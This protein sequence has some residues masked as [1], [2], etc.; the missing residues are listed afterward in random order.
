MI[1]PITG[2]AWVFGDNIDT[3]ALAPGHH[4]KGS[5]EEMASHCLETIAP[6]FA[7]AVSPGDVLVAGENFGI[8]SS[9]EQAVQV[10][11]HLGILA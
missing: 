11:V 8:G 4:M 7:N 3:D 6:E 9:R 2:K 10:L 5:L 1:E